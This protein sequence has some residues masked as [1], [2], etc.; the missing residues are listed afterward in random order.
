MAQ[1]ELTMS[2]PHQGSDICTMQIHIKNHP[3]IELIMT[4]EEVDDFIIQVAE[5][6][7]GAATDIL[8]K[9]QRKMH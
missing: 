4:L 7:I 1:I 6:A 9:R 3:T 5:Q 2:P 8:N